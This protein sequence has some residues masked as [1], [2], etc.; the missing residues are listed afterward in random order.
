M[1]VPS[2]PS[3]FEI[4]GDS[5]LFP[6]YIPDKRA[7]TPQPLSAFLLIEN[8]RLPWLVLSFQMDAPTGTSAGSFSPGLVSEKILQLSSFHNG[9]SISRLF[10]LLYFLL[11]PASPYTVSAADLL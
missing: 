5:W 8:K 1:P 3:F 11:L 6:G 9:I 10:L 4:Q 7:Q 2:I